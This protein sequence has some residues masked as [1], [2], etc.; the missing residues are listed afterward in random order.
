[1][2]NVSEDFIQCENKEACLA[3]DINNPT[4]IC[5]PGYIGIICG[6]C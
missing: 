3:G 1:M 6:D 2:S 5:A 4:G